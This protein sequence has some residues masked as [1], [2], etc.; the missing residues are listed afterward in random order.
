VCLGDADERTR[1]KEPQAARDVRRAGRRI[2]HHGDEPR[3]E[4]R[5]QHRIQRCAHRHEH[6]RGLAASH[7]R[8]GKLAGDRCGGA[9]ELRE[10]RGA[11]ASP[12]SLDDRRGVGHPA[13]ALREQLGEVHASGF[14]YKA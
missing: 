3:A 8:P 5:E 9:V 7:P 2:D 13:R 10:R 11:L 4:Q 6:E 12:R 14:A 1:R